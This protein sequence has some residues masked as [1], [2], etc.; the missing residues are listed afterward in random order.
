MSKPQGDAP[1]SLLEY[2]CPGTAERVCTRGRTICATYC[3]G[4]SLVCTQPKGHDGPHV[5]C[6]FNHNYAI[7]D[8]GNIRWVDDEHSR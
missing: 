1:E 8:D 5:A 6:G 3:D 4:S 7:W 2:A